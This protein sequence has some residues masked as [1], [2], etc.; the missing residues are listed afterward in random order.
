VRALDYLAEQGLLTVKVADL[1]QRYRR[2]RMPK[3]V[4][5]L[6]DALHGR[7]LEREKREIARLNQVVELAGHDG[8]QASRLGAHF[9]EPLSEPCGRCSWCLNGQKPARLLPRPEPV[10]DAEVWRQA[11]ALRHDRPDVLS[12]PRALARFLCGL[13][14]PW[15]SRNKLTSHALFGALEAVP[16]AEVLRRAEG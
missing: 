15:L 2:L 6:A 12:E 9:G 10:I 4:D 13:S 5:A 14:S 11:A 16:F 1:R 3:D 7:T 8:C